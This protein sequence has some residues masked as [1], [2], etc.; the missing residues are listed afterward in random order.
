MSFLG[1]DLR[2][3]R[4]S[5]PDWCAVAKALSGLVEGG[6]GVGAEAQISAI[7]IIRRIRD[8]T[9]VAP[10]PRPSAIMLYRP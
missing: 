10:T 2:T 5:E 3:F 6:G 1:N 9:V 8:D 7:S 4:T